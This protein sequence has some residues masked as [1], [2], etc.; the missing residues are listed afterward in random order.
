MLLTTEGWT[1]Q[2]EIQFLVPFFCIWDMQCSKCRSPVIAKYG[3][4]TSVHT[5][6]MIKNWLMI[7]S[8]YD[9][10]NSF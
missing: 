3:Y 8:P 7:N 6:L 1:L 9:L 2:G 4:L 5:L 10:K